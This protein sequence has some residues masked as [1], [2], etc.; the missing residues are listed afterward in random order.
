M[1]IKTLEVNGNFKYLWLK[2]V[3]DVDLSQHCAK[4]LIGK[5]DNRISPE[6]CIYKDI[7][8]QDKYYYLCG[9]S[10]PY[11]WSMNF[12]LAF[13]PCNGNKI[14]FSKNGI[15]VEIEDAEIIEISPNNIN[16]LDVNAGKKAFSTCR[17]WQF[18]HWFAR[19]I[20]RR[21]S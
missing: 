9:V 19:E 10:K 15:C 17:N 11:N 13:R 21:V 7:D 12:H 1:K 18:A 2:T 5:Y 16:L 6:K 3:E 14:A 4:C 20:K 8:L